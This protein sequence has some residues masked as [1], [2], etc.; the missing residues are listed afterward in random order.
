METSRIEQLLIFS[1][2][3]QIERR[4]ERRRE[5]FLLSLIIHAYYLGTSQVTRVCEE[6]ECTTSVVNTFGE[7]ERICL[8]SLV[9][10]VSHLLD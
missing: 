6:N 2:S 3:N 9:V 8:S 4:E 5:H 1:K 7:V 10:L